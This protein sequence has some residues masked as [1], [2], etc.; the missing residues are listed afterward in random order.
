MFRDGKISDINWT[1]LT[2][3]DIDTQNA[4]LKTFFMFFRLPLITLLRI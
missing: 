1:L 4:A 2:P 3:L